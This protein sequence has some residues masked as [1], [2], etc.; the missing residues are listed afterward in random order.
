MKLSVSLPEGDVAFLDAYA[1]AHSVRSRSGVLHEALELLRT[2]ELAADYEAAW[3]EWSAD[4]VNALW[5]T[6]T[7][8][9][10]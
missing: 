8:D 1:R 7:G 9:G 6:T 2:Q 5:E 4:D 3:D 10:I